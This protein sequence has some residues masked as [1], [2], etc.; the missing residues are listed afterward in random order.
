VTLVKRSSVEKCIEVMKNGYKGNASFYIFEP[1]DGA[2]SI[3]L[4]KPNNK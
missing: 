2:R 3:D 1:S 4:K